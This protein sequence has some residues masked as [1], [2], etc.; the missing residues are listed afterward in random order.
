MGDVSILLTGL[1]FGIWSCP[2]TRPFVCRQVSR[3]M[4]R[5]VWPSGSLPLG[6]GSARPTGLHAE[7]AAAL[8]SPSSSSHL[9]QPHPRTSFQGERVWASPQPTASPPVIFLASD[10]IPATTPPRESAVTR[11][12]ARL[13]ETQKRGCGWRGR[14]AESQEHSGRK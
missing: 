10:L 5:F 1:S 9:S 11:L 6:E 2:L 14:E 3:R 4:H 7:G 8:S 13:W 12:H